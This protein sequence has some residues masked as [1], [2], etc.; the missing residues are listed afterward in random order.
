MSKFSANIYSVV[1][2]DEEKGLE[3]WLHFVDEFYSPSGVLRRG[4]YS[5]EQ[6]TKQF[7]ISYPALPRYYLTEF[8]SGVRR[9]QMV[10][11]NA[12]EKVF[13]NGTYTVE[14]L[15]TFFYWFDNEAAHVSA[16]LFFFTVNPGGW[17]C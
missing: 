1:Q 9:I 14:C 4:V 2:D 16:F 10:I 17:Q 11:E 6:G 5:Q 7:A 15:V 8:N 3:Y 12:T 13:S